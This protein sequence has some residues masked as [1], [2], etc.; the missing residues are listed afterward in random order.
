[1]YANRPYSLINCQV[2]VTESLNE[3]CAALSSCADPTV[4]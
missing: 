2:L 3:I 4:P 1:M